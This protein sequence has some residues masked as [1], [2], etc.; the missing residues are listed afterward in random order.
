MSCH[1]S[2]LVTWKILTS[3]GY[4]MTHQTM[5]RPP[6]SLALLPP[7]N[8]LQIRLRGVVD[9]PNWRQRLCQS[10]RDLQPL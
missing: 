1:A 5:N 3:S 4:V 8:S 6:K 2:K 10:S 9:A 7:S